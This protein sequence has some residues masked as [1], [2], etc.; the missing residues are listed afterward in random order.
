MYYITLGIFLKLEKGDRVTPHGARLLIPV[1][2]SP[3]YF[4]AATD[5]SI[6]LLVARYSLRQRVL[7]DVQLLSVGKKMFYT[8]I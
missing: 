7:F 5:N 6:P 2:R 8:S 1:P 4:Y 3:S